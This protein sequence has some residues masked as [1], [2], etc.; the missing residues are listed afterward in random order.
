MNLFNLKKKHLFLIIFILLC[1]V[2]ASVK[3]SPY[4]EF[5]IFKVTY[6]V[7]SE[8][9]TASVNFRNAITD[10]VKK[11]VFLLKLR[12]TNS[13]LKTENEQLSAELNL[14][15]EVLQENDRLKKAL[16]FM[17]NSSLNLLPA[18]V[19]GQDLIH[20]NSLITLNKGSVHGVK[21]H[22]GVITSEGVIGY[23]FR[24]TP[25]SCQV[26]TILSHLSTVPA[27]HQTHRIM[28]LVT[29]YQNQ[30]LH[31]KYSFLK[32]SQKIFTEGTSVIT[33]QTKQ[34]PKGIPLG[35]IEKIVKNKTNPLLPVVVLKPAASFV[36]LS[37]VFILLTSES[38]KYGKE[39]K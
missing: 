8:V 24:V 20:R 28:G 31:F 27:I 19:V 18:Q 5:F 39:F 1:V 21:K 23:V 6:F 2:Y 29:S 35:T 11:Y 32:D 10:T 30:Q 37:E 22:M 25:H 17:Q 33:A 15:E 4:K 13:V 38:Q 3:N 36:S 26:I 12:E 34:F 7:F 14:L 16:Q 9:Q